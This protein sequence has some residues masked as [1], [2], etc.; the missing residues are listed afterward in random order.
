LQLQWQSYPKANECNI[1]SEDFFCDYCGKKGHQEVVS[2]AK[3]LKQKQLQL[4]RQNLTASS[5]ALQPK[6]KAP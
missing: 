1:P 2:F 3:F 5:I 6:A 4:P